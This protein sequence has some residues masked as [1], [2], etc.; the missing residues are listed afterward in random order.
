MATA[1]KLH[2][3]GAA[4]VSQSITR[5]VD[6]AAELSDTLE[7]T[8][9]VTAGLRTNVDGLVKLVCAGDSAAVTLFM[10]GGMDYPYRVKQVF[11]TGTDAAVKTG[12]IFGLF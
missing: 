3:P 10:L 11:S 5:A 1:P 12:K 7:L 9:G 4:I 2:S 8:T 6:L